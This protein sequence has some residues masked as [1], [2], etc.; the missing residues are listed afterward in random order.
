[1]GKSME[2]SLITPDL[3][4][5]V[6]S[7]LPT[8]TRSIVSQFLARYSLIGFMSSLSPPCFPRTRPKI[9]RVLTKNFLSP[10]RFTL[11]T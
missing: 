11:T 9:A 5:W 8:P 10:T 1:M 6:I 3:L 2:N 7:F 4:L